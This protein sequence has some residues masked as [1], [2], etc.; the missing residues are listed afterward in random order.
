MKILLTS[1]VVAAALLSA[2]P[3]AA[4]PRDNVN[5]THNKH[6]QEQQQRYNRDIVRLDIPVRVRGDERLHLRRLMHRHGYNPD[7]YQLRKVVFNNQSRR[8]AGARLRVGNQVVT[9]RH[10]DRGRN[11]LHAPR[12]GD[13]RWVLAFNNAR[14]D[15]VRLVLEPK[16][17]WAYHDAPRHAPRRWF[18]D[19]HWS[20]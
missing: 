11:Q 13:G 7:H 12:H 18:E 10:I 2:D 8:H 15:Q 19:R 14:V 20:R 9:K 3:A 16:Y 5:P 4:K 6:H 17:H 1:T